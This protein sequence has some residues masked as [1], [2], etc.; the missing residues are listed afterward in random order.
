[1]PNVQ[2][3]QIGEPVDQHLVTVS[4]EVFGPG[5]DGGID[6]PR[7]AVAATYTRGS[8]GEPVCVEYR[9]RVLRGDDPRELL[10]DLQETISAMESHAALDLVGEGPFPDVGIP[11]RVF[12]VASQSRLLQKAREALRRSDKRRSHV[13]PETLEL[14]SPGQRRVGRPPVR[15][16]EEKLRILAAVE[17]ATQSGESLEVVAHTFHMSRSSLRDLLS[18]ARHD[19]DPR[20]FTGGGQGR[21]GGALTPEARLLLDQLRGAS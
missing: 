16:L 7:W 11:R 20:L 9:A 15:P 5:A 6:V 19:S 10:M 1:L 12:E 2:T 4:S 17:D 18:W 21:G 8:N 13:P 14:L 3:T